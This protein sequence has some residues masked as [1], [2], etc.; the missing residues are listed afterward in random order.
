MF[1]V[2]FLRNYV[3]YGETRRPL[4]TISNSIRQGRILSPR[5]LSVYMDNLSKL[6]INFG[7]SCFI[8]NV[9][10]NHVFYADDVCLMAPFAM[11]LQE[12]LNICH[13]YSISV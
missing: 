13:S 1:L 5:L 2:L 12:L 8:D 4:F 9:C 3:Y 6:L 10:F 7:I 11:A